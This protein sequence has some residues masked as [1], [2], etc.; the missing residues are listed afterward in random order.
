LPGGGVVR[1]FSVGRSASSVES[2][3]EVL[4][5]SVESE[6]RRC[7]VGR[8]ES[9]DEPDPE[10]AEVDGAGVGVEAGESDVVVSPESVRRFIVGRS[11]SSDALVV[12]D[13]LA[14]V[15]AC[16][17]SAEL[18]V[19]EELESV[20]RR[21]VGREESSEEVDA[22]VDVAGVEALEVVV[23]DPEPLASALSESD[24]RRIVGREESSA[25]AVVELELSVLFPSFG[26]FPPL[27]TTCGSGPLFLAAYTGPCDPGLNN[28]YP[29]QP[30]SNCV[31]LLPSRWR[32][33]ANSTVPSGTPDFCT[34][35]TVPV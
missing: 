23:A 13:V 4:L 11:G 6:V 27:A 14:G 10:E 2:V 25:E 34:S 20:R 33:Y 7:I 1:F 35:K 28:P 12:E 29:S 26:R 15:F 18:A 22:G 5:V 24:R 17:E 31:T 8:F 19:S 3:V 32:S 30:S 16:V 9:S 21:I